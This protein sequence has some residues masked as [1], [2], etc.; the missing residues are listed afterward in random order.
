MQKL[1]HRCLSVALVTIDMNDWIVLI[2]KNCSF[3]KCASTIG[4]DIA[5]GLNG[6]FTWMISFRYFD[7]AYTGNLFLF[8]YECMDLIVSVF[9]KLTASHRVLLTNYSS[10]KAPSYSLRNSDFD[11]PTFNTINYGKH[12]LRY[13]GPYIWSKLDN[14]LKA[15]RILNLLRRTLGK[16]I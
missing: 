13:Q 9:S 16:K 11:I 10:K 6:I 5:F 1:S 15:P 14:K 7:L 3:C 12:S 8:V 2:G 4:E